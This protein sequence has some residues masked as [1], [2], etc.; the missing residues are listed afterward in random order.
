M[1]TSWDEQLGLL[2][3][4]KTTLNSYCKKCFEAPTP[5]AFDTG[6]TRRSLVAAEGL[7]SATNSNCK[8]CFLTTHYLAK[9]IDTIQK[10][11]Q[12]VCEFIA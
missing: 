9:V 1:R 5:C 3:M 8:K 12:P 4:Y 6:S 10:G 2:C 7:A 11:K